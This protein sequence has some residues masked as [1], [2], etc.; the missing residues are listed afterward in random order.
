MCSIDT[1][2]GEHPWTLTKESMLSVYPELSKN[3]ELGGKF[4]FLHTKGVIHRRTSHKKVIRNRGQKDSVNC[5]QGMLNFHTHPISCYLQEK[6]VWGWTS[7]EDLRET[8]IFGLKGTLAH[9]VLSVEGCYLVQISN[10]AIDNLIN[11]RLPEI[12]NTLATK[13]I[14][15]FAST[16]SHRNKD[17]DDYVKNFGISKKEILDACASMSNPGIITRILGDILRGI[18]IVFI[19]IYFRS[20]HRF[21]TY[22]FCAKTPV[23]PYDFIKM[24]ESFRLENMFDHKSNVKGCGPVIKC[25]GISVGSKRVSTFKNYIR[26]YENNTGFYICD[27]VGNVIQ[28]EIPIREIFDVIPIVAQVSK[29]FDKC[30]KWFHISLTEN[31][32]LVAGKYVPYI[33]LHPKQQYE[34][35]EYYNKNYEGYIKNNTY[36][37]IPTGD[38]TFRWYQLHGDC[39]YKDIHKHR[40][41]HKNGSS[42]VF[43]I[44]SPKCQWT[45]KADELLRS[46]GVPFTHDYRDTIRDAVHSSGTQT[47]PAIYVDGKYIGGYTD[48]EKLMKK[49]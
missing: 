15:Y 26:D 43:I 12:P 11:L 27:N 30:A 28:I 37:L 9:A 4:T 48:L 44:G 46:H 24:V 8:I 22:S 10:C 32:V 35:L 31:L 14:G 2:N 45:R 7:G 42:G 39:S 33:G 16:I 6:T 5:P 3:Y 18:M 36:P 47:I 13:L 23:T 20:T 19:E 25:N 17:S 38:A 49:T 41:T 29:N 40:Q 21:R 34:I 1:E